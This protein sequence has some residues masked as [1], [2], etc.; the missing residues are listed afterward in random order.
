MRS[1]DWSSDVCSSDLPDALA[2]IYPVVSMDPVIAHAMSRE[3][4]IGADADAA[5]ENAYSPERNVR[6]DQPPLWLLHAED[7]A[8][9][10]VENS[11]RLRAA[12]RGIGASRGERR[13]GDGSGSKCG[14]R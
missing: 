9:V 4:L 3:K 8:V 1:S 11:A 2:A 14:S 13:G 12:T 7:D 10:K 6:A 5:R